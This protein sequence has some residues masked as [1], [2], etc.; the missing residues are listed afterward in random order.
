MARARIQNE[1]KRCLKKK[2]FKVSQRKPPR[3]HGKRRWP[4]G[5]F[6]KLNVPS[7]PIYNEAHGHFVPRFS[8]QMKTRPADHIARIR[9][10]KS[11][12]KFTPTPPYTLLLKREF[13]C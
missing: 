6:N 8:L 4:A 9:K 3:L 7:R 5:G 11:E 13:F 12:I 2:K 1:C 10:N